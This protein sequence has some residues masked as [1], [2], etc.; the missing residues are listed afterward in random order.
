MRD[1]GVFDEEEQRCAREWFE[2]TLA[3]ARDVHTIGERRASEGILLALDRWFVYRD[4]GVAGDGT[5]PLTE[6]DLVVAAVM[7]DGVLREAGAVR[8]DP[9]ASLLGNQLGEHLTLTFD[10]VDRLG[11]AFLDAI[12]ERFT[13]DG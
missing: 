7:T 4:R 10:D 9:A 3:A 1:R 6:V 5:N 12:A 2:E 11:H 13:A 8:Y